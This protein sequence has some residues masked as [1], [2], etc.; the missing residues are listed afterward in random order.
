MGEELVAWDVGHA[1]GKN[2]LLHLLSEFQVAFEPFAL[3]KRLVH[4]S[5]LDGDRR[6]ARDGCQHVEVVLDELAAVAG[7]ELENA[8]RLIVRRQERYAH[9]RAD[10]QVG[11]RGADGKVLVV[12]GVLAQHRLFLAEHVIDD[13]PADARGDLVIGYGSSERRT[14]L[15]AVL[16]RLAYQ[17]LARRDLAASGRAARHRERSPSRSRGS[18]G[19]RRRSA[20]RWRGFG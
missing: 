3:Q 18:W 9:D 12:A 17:S 19:R 13:R 6:L 14:L 1:C 10:L 11:D 5:V 15:G 16:E 7:V 4:R 2:R 8:Q 20:T